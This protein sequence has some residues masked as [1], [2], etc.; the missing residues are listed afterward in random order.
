MTRLLG[1][2][3]TCTELPT[4]PSSIARLAM[5]L[6]A[7]FLVVGLFS[8]TVHNNSHNEQ[9]YVTAGYLLAH[10]AAPLP[11]LRLRPDALLTPG[12]C[13]GFPAYGRPLSH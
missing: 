7:G 1:H 11:G 8:Q 5:A 6:L 3:I 10:G 9:M 2:D 13:A 4:K 12:L